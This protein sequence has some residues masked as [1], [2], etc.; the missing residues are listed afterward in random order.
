MCF[1]SVHH[2][3]QTQSFSEY[4]KQVLIHNGYETFI[5]RSVSDKVVFCLGERQGVLV[6]DECDSWYNRVGDFL[7]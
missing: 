7:L 2:D 1:F 4:L 5:H 3:S 6:D